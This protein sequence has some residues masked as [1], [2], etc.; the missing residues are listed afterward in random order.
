MQILNGGID[1][2]KFTWKGLCCRST[3]LSVVSLARKIVRISIAKFFD[4]LT[5]DYFK[6]FSLFFIMIPTN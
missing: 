6:I 5:I 4:N 2:N 1:Q 3:T